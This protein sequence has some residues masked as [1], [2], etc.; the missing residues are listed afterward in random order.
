MLLSVGL[1]VDRGLDILGVRI[2]LL[3][4]YL[5]RHLQ[6]VLGCDIRRRFSYEDDTGLASVESLA[7]V[8]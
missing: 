6:D 8:G 2:D 7:E 1:S 3:L 5:G 4:L